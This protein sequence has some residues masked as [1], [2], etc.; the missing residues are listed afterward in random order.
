MSSLQLDGCKIHSRSQYKPAH[1]HA[2]TL[3]CAIIWLK[4]P[5]VVPRVVVAIPIILIR[6]GR[7]GI[8]SWVESSVRNTRMEKFT[9]PK[10]FESNWFYSDHNASHKAVLSAERCFSYTSHPKFKLSWC[11][12]GLI[13]KKKKENGNRNDWHKQYYPCT[14]FYIFAVVWVSETYPMPWAENLPPRR[15]EPPVNKHTRT[16]CPLALQHRE[17]NTSTTYR[18][19]MPRI[20]K[21]RGSSWVDEIAINIFQCMRVPSAGWQHD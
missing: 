6:A 19:L 18:A 15:P 8:V 13:N 10:H 4:A 12:L 3:T 1:T 11:S 7:L 5:S 21:W 9:L 17:R 16:A 2:K 20:W 14:D